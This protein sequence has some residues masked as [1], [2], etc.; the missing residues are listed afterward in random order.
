MKMRQRRRKKQRINEAN[1]APKIR[2]GFTQDASIEEAFQHSER[3][4][5]TSARE[6]AQVLAGADDRDDGFSPFVADNDARAVWTDGVTDRV[7]YDVHKTYT[8]KGMARLKEGRVCLR[9]DEPLDPSFPSECPLC[10]YA[11]KERQIMDI[12]ME[13]EGEKHIGPSRPVS[14]YL[15]EQDERVAKRE[16]D[17]KIKEGR[18]RGRG[19]RRA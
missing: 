4:R 7:Q 14:E 2:E 12:A 9:C 18:S 5:V 1:L 11:V 6:L 15:A 19:A 17:R 10:G 13:F 3:Q 16:F 8:A